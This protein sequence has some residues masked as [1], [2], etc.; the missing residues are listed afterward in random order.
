MS[1]SLNKLTLSDFRNDPAQINRLIE[2]GEPVLLTENGKPRL[3]VQDAY[4]Y[5]NLLQ[6]LE[7]AEAVAG[8]RQGLTSMANGK[9][10]SASSFF[11]F[12]RHKHQIP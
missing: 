7:R 11:E 9:G 8:I 6:A 2:R 10:L 12:M 3:V 4:A 5:D 1:Q